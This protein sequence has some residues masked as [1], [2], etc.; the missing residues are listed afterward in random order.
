[1]WSRKEFFREI[2]R[3]S[4][5]KFFCSFYYTLENPSETCATERACKLCQE[6]NKTER[7]YT[8]TNKLA[9]VRPDVMKRKRLTG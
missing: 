9:N 7:F 1:M 2:F 5:G 6:R 4:L 8:D 3:E